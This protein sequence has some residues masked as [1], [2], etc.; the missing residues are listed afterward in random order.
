MYTYSTIFNVHTLRTKLG[1]K[2]DTQKLLTALCLSRSC[3]SNTIISLSATSNT[4]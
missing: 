2:N 3:L 1:R 4:D